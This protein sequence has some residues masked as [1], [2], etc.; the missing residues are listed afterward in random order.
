MFCADSLD[1]GFKGQIMHSRWYRRPEDFV[2]KVSPR[3][4]F[5]NSILRC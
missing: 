5:P 2:G 1:S 3:F 4:L